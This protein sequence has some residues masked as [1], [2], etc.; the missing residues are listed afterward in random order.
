[1][2]QPSDLWLNASKFTHSDE[3]EQLNALVEPL[4][5]QGPKWY[6]V[7]AATY[8]QMWE[9]GQTPLPQPIYLAEAE[10]SSLPSRDEGRTIP[11]RVYRPQIGALSRGIIV[12]FHG[13]GFVLGSH[14][15]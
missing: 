1:M 6:E 14:R 9:D 2:D 3:A 5:N 11:I 8:R 7:G 12:H 4:S 15:Q 13:G 10:D